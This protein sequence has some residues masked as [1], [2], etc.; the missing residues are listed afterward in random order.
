MGEGKLDRIQSDNICMLD[1]YEALDILLDQLELLTALVGS[2]V[3]R[4][5]C[6]QMNLERKRRR[7]VIANRLGLIHGS[8]MICGSV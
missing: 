5:K 2:V 3:V 4:V 7:N 8:K 1:P 6:D